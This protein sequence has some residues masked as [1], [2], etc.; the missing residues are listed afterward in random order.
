MASSDRLW[1]FG[2]SYG[3]FDKNWIK[4]LHTTL[5]VT[6]QVTNKS[7]TSLNW[8]LFMWVRYKDLINP[9]DRVL[10]LVPEETRFQVSV[11]G[12]TWH[13]GS[14]GILSNE[15]QFEAP[16]EL[17]VSIEQTLYTQYVPHM[18][19]NHLL[20][21]KW[22]QEELQ[23]VTKYN[24]IIHTISNLLTREGMNHSE[25]INYKPHNDKGIF[26]LQREVHNINT[27]NL[28]KK[29]K[30]MMDKIKEHPNHWVDENGW[31][32]KFYAQ[33]NKTLNRLCDDKK[34]FGTFKFIN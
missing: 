2:D 6:P 9:N 10:F 3:V 13:C 12:K 11:A 33:Y 17:K 32:N 7:G 14:S 28:T 8:A 34:R 29:A 25:V 23:S 26:E 31:H 30:F 24:A 22:L 16:K 5:G 4:D 15:Y 1:V 21:C 19:M 27:A 20:A 18:H